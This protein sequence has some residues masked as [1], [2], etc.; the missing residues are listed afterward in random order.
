MVTDDLGD[1]GQSQ[2]T[3]IGSGRDKRIEKMGVP[4][5]GLSDEQ[6]RGL[7]QQR[8]NQFRDNA[9]VT[10]AEAATIMLDG[11]RNETWRILIGDDAKELDSLVRQ[12]PEEAYEVDFMKRVTKLGRSLPAPAKK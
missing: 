12:Y 5:D 8:L 9:P 1:E 3:A 6:V 7:V 2:T 10:A 4:T 11:V